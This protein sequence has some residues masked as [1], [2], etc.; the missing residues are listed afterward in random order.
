M[1]G[2]EQPTTNGTEEF[3]AYLK[4]DLVKWTCVVKENGTKAE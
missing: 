4:A 1:P 2:C 3:A